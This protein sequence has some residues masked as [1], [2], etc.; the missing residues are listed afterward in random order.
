M[1]LVLFSENY[2]ENDVVSEINSIIREFGYCVSDVFLKNEDS[3]VAFKAAL[4]EADYLADVEEKD[5]VL[6]V[7]YFGESNP[8]FIKAREMIGDRP[9]LSYSDG[10]TSCRLECKVGDEYSVLYSL[11]TWTVRA[12]F[13]YPEGIEGK[14]T[15]LTLVDL[16]F[17]TVTKLFK[18]PAGKPWHAVEV[19]VGGD[20]RIFR[21][22]SGDGN[23]MRQYR[24]DATGS[25]TWNECGWGRKDDSIV[26]NNHQFLVGLAN[27]MSQAGA[28]IRTFDIRPI[29]GTDLALV[30]ECKADTLPPPVKVVCFGNDY[31]ESKVRHLV[32]TIS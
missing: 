12:P 10:K 7:H 23:S 1:A 21:L 9:Y 27:H 19:D 26:A 17:A 25:I 14:G 31:S 4:D 20:D 5:S 6:I 28:V 11:A 3:I 15:A 8:N 2:S 24:V 18:L 30:S 22:F 32:E 13:G 16:D 29:L